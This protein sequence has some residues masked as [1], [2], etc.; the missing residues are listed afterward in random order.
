MG[1]K[2]DLQL[3]IL[4]VM[5]SDDLRVMKSDDHLVAK[6]EVAEIPIEITVVADDDFRPQTNIQLPSKKILISRLLDNY[7]KNRGEDYSEIIPEKFNEISSKKVEMSPEGHTPVLEVEI[8][9]LGKESPN[10]TIR[11]RKDLV[12]N[13]PLQSSLP[14][15]SQ[16]LPIDFQRK[17]YPA[18]V[19]AAVAWGPKLSSQNNVDSVAKEEVYIPGSGLEFFK[20]VEEVSEK[21]TKAEGPEK[22]FHEEIGPLKKNISNDKKVT[23]QDS[24][25][26]ISSA[27]RVARSNSIMA[28]DR[29]KKLDNYLEVTDL[30]RYDSKKIVELVESYATRLKINNI[31]HLNLVLQDKA[32]GKIKLYL[33]RNDAANGF[34]LRVMAAKLGYDFFS[35]NQGV[36]VSGLKE[37]G[38]DLDLK[39]N[40]F[41]A[42]SSEQI[43]YTDGDPTAKED[44]RRRQKLWQE[45]Q[46][47]GYA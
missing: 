20:N 30:K 19:E 6:S 4:P 25:A 44:S 3:Q 21:F 39:V 24:D 17:S 18:P 15:N 10:K 14:I 47:R 7:L 23:M 42:E 1:A 37:K 41:S 11:P 12:V 26:I 46:E 22:V 36:I 27:S 45:Y 43:V 33:T 32:L 28:F 5:G 31:D 34:E 38:L 9:L 40:F 29:I 16:D 13:L 2:A 8:S 35:K